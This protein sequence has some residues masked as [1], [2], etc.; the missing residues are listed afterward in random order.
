MENDLTPP[1][2]LPQHEDMIGRYI[3]E[4]EKTNGGYLL[5]TS[6]DGQLPPRSIYYFSDALDAAEAYNRYTDFG[7]S[8]EYLTVWLYEPGNKVNTKVLKRPKAGECSYVRKNYIDASNLLKSFKDKM[9]YDQYLEL[10]KGFA[11]IFSQDNI[12]FNPQRFLEDS[13]CKEMVE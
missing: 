1:E 13:G 4:T 11:L 9:D 2:L 5:A 10:V 12:R 3:S 7:F 8:K 6:R